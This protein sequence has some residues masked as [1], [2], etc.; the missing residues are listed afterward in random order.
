MELELGAGCKVRYTTASGN[1]RKLNTKVPFSEL[2]TA[3]GIEIRLTLAAPPKA[4][5][6]QY[7]HTAK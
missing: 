1:D 4:A 5:K 2:K 6:V 7:V 3:M